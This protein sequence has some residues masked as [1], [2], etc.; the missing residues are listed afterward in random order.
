LFHAFRLA[1]TLFFDAIDLFSPDAH[2]R[3]AVYAEGGQ[4]RPLVGFWTA[5]ELASDSK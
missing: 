4:S 5:K 3:M 2:R 1:V